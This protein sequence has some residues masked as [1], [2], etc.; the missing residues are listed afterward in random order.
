MFAIVRALNF[1]NFELMEVRVQ[2]SSG[3]EIGGR[4]ERCRRIC[5]CEDV[6][7]SVLGDCIQSKGEKNSKGEVF[8]ASRLNMKLRLK[9]S[10]NKNQSHCQI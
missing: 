3:E 6:K 5:K 9:L 10:L 7:K 1:L 4:I 8:Q 2:M